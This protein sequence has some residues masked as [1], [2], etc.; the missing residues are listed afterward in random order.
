M[1]WTL[2]LLYCDARSVLTSGVQNALKRDTM[3]SGV[4]YTTASC[5]TRRINRIAR[6]ALLPGERE[7]YT[8]ICIQSDQQHGLRWPLVAVAATIRNLQSVYCQSVLFRNYRGHK[9]SQKVLMQ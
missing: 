2:A 7:I 3:I 9:S 1:I 4:R 8:P 6:Y 5:N